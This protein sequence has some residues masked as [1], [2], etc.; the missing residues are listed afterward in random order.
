MNQEEFPTCVS[1]T[2]YPT[3]ASLRR[4]GDADR[5][6]HRGHVAPN[7]EPENDSRSQFNK[8]QHVFFHGSSYSFTELARAGMMLG[9]NCAINSATR[10]APA[11]MRTKCSAPDPLPG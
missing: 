5:G 6:N 10:A 9:T 3:S 2:V 11:P 1:A 7:H 4:R 8:N